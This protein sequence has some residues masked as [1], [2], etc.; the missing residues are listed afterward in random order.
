M[1]NAVQPN[2]VQTPTDATRKNFSWK[3][4]FVG[5]AISAIV[6]AVLLGGWYW[7]IASQSKSNSSNK[8][9]TPVTNKTSTSSAKK[10]TS[11]AKPDETAGWKTYTENGISFKY[12]PTW[13]LGEVTRSSDKFAVTKATSVTSLSGFYLYFVTNLQGLGGG[14]G[15]GQN[16]PH[17]VNVYV[18][19]IKKAGFDNYKGE[20]VNI[21]EWGVSGGFLQ[22]KGQNFVRKE[23]LL[24]DHSDFPKLG[25]NGK[26]CLVYE[27]ELNGELI[28]STNSSIY[29]TAFHGQ[30]PDD[31]EYQKLTAEK[32]FGLADVKTA[33]KIMSTIS[34]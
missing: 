12:P 21:V 4:V 10:A 3:N 1:E 29:A 8:V 18:Y 24:G 28:F 20:S 27:Q 26:Q 15:E 11:S 5:I 19:N 23:V 2:V 6:I 31:S 30:Y 9:T 14:C 32:Y 34:Y 16:D 17:L 13:T 7:Y 22:E 33:E 25:D